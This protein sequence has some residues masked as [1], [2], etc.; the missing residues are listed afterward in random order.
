MIILF[1]SI[2]L[3][4]LVLLT[5]GVWVLEL[6]TFRISAEHDDAGQGNNNY[7][8]I[9]RIALIFITVA[10][11]GLFVINL[12]SGETSEQW[13]ASHA[14]GL[15]LI[16][17]VLSPSVL[18]IQYNPRLKGLSAFTLPILAFVLAWDV[19]AFNWSYRPFNYEQ[20]QSVWLV[21]HLVFV[22]LGT[23]F[24][25]IA[26]VAAMIYLFVQSR[27]KHK[28]SLWSLGQIASL[29][30]LERIIIR[31]ASISFALFTVGLVTG[32]VILATTSFALQSNWWLYP[33]IVLAVLAWAGYALLMNV[34]QATL[35]R[36]SR[37]AWIAVLGLVLIF[38]IY[39]ILTALPAHQ[40]MPDDRSADQI[41]SAK[42]MPP[43]PKTSNSKLGG[44]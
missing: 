27:L 6:R 14:D 30:S 42:L 12:I 31:S 40:N 8:F 20:I 35:F 17:A 25:L 24:A 37:A 41:Q 44:E 11:A 4:I 22:Y 33:K 3:V 23:L 28:Q 5:L 15:L 1:T 18:V 26:A 32:L 7:S 10:T 9:K 13:L 38:V 16:A 29:E 39:G 2:L 36:G 19:C 43:P 34:R 21:I